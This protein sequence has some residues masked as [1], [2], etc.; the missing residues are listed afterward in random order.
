LSAAAAISKSTITGWCH[1]IVTYSFWNYL[2][3][4]PFNLWRCCWCCS[5]G[6]G[7]VQWKEVTGREGLVSGCGVGFR[8]FGGFEVQTKEMMENGV[9]FCLSIAKDRDGLARFPGPCTPV[10][11]VFSIFARTLDYYFFLLFHFYLKF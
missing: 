10:P 7:W 9:R 6:L 4:F 2:G 3:C 1:D 11:S 5:S 8:G